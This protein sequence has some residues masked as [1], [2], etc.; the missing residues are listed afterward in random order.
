[1]APTIV[2]VSH[3]LKLPPE[4]Q[5]LAARFSLSLLAEEEL[6]AIVQRKPLAGASAIEGRGFAPTIGPCSRL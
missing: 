1:M 2:L 6:L 5:R 4:V 3:A